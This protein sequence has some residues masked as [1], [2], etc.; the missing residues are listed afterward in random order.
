MKRE[1]EKSSCLRF[2]H[3]ASIELERT[4]ADRDV[5]DAT[6]LGNSIAEAWLAPATICPTG[7]SQSTAAH[8]DHV[9][10]MLPGPYSS[11]ARG[12]RT[13]P[14]AAAAPRTSFDVVC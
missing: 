8:F 5:F 14:S 13:V 7:F 2:C 11:G 4:G 12:L 1:P 9:C 6:P 10:Q 3:G